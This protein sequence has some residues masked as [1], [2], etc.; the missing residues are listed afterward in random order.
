M[1]GIGTERVARWWPA[2]AAALLLAASL[3]LFWP[4]VAEYDSVE[5]F[6][7][8]LTGEV[9]NWHPPIMVRLWQL[10]HAL[11][12][13]QQQPML[14]LQL[15]LYWIGLGLL[16]AALARL[17]RRVAAA[18]VLTIGVLP[19][20]LGW[21]AIVLKDGQL[22]GAIVA[23]IGLV[24]WFR[25][26]ERRA[27]VWAMV[28]ASL[29]LAYAAL[30]RSNGVFATAAVMAYLLPDRLGRWRWTV[31]A[32]MLVVVL[33]GEGAINVLLLRADP[34]H[35]ERAEAAY[36]LAGIAARVPPGEASGLPPEQVAEIGARHC[37]VPLYWDPLGDDGRCGDVWAA[38]LHRPTMDLYGAL[39]LAIVHH[40]IAYA[41]HRLAH[42][43]STGRWL[44]PMRW[45][46]GA[47]PEGG[48]P[49][50]LGM[51]QPSSAATGYLRMAGTSVDA[52]LGWPIAW[53]VVA[54]TA[55]TV[56]L[57]RPHSPVRDLALAL[58]ASAVTLEA[59]FTFLSISSD[60]RYHLWSMLAAALASILLAGER[61]GPER[62]VWRTGAVVL[63]LV[64]LAGTTARLMLPVTTAYPELDE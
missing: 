18:M 22:A 51:R 37:A 12:G 9:D 23:A 64:I 62:G 60:L 39:A 8:A 53:L 15:G 36:D 21:M 41:A 32:A 11:F 13:G 56:S 24:A 3:A 61:P 19:P 35:V 25:L 45:P 7:Q 26:R 1:G 50:D 52:P 10:L 38:M 4:G 30:V 58:A 34:T 31:A 42:L 17:G 59:S 27:P 46:L 47:P 28:L 6:R 43:N 20:F 29:L 2:F 14:V 44:V 5:Q 57:R 33:A 40:P 48:E 16:A 49:N 63:L 54:M 55:L